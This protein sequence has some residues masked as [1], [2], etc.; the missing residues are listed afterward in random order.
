MRLPALLT[1]LALAVALSPL[2]CSAAEDDATS[3]SGDE[4]TAEDELRSLTLTEA[5]D[6]KTV[7][8]AKGQNLVL[9]LQSN[10]STGFR[11]KVVSTD[12]TFG[13]PATT[14]F[15]KNG[16][17]AGAAGVERMTWKTNGPLDMTGS[18]EVKL[19]YKRT[20]EEDASPAKT[21]S[22]TVN[23]VGV[24]CP[25]LVPPAPG[26]CDDGRIKATKDAN[27]CTTAYECVTDCRATG[28]GD[29]R[30]CSFCWAQFACIPNGAL[31]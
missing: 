17:A 9:R 7:S 5:D 19:E 24:E 22:F 28:C 23:V 4:G 27:G 20:F 15:L 21:F 30:S 26:F 11:W 14:R 12:R 2:G 25:A 31:C 1:V 6:G 10:P 3:T 29:G 18:H 16:D 8:V 13:Y